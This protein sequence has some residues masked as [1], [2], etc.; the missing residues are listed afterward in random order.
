MGSLFERLG[1]SDAVDAIVSIFFNEKVVTDPALAFM[2]A[3]QQHNNNDFD[4]VKQ[5]MEHQKQ[6]LTFA[7]GGNPKLIED[8]TALRNAHAT[9]NN[10]HFPPNCILI[11]SNSI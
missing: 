9:I 2:F 6:F 5:Q 3:N 7:L 4:D 1:G 10:G 8:R 11:L